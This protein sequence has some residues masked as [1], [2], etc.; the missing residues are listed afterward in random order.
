MSNDSNTPRAEENRPKNSHRQI[1]LYVTDAME[2][3]ISQEIVRR[4]TVM[5][6]C[7][8]QLTSNESMAL[9]VISVFINGKRV[10]ALVDTGCSKSV[11]SRRLINSDQIEWKNEKTILADGSSVEVGSIFIQMQVRGVTLD[12]SVNIMNTFSCYFDVLLGVDVIYKLGGI[13]FTNGE[14]KFGCETEINTSNASC[15]QK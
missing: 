4:E 3:D 14:L 7:R 13:K 10:K 9:P 6:V 11:I 1:K 8:R 12:V 5:E 15:N 2:W